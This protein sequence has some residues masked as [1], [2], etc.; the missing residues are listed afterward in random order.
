MIQCRQNLSSP[1]RV[2]LRMLLNFLL[3][4]FERTLQDT[5]FLKIYLSQDLLP[6]DLGI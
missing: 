1:I 6:K 4:P 3:K 5:V 2:L